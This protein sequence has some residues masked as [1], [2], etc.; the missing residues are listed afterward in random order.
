LV[1][2]PVLLGASVVRERNRDR[3][4]RLAAVVGRC[5]RNVALGVGYEQSRGARLAV[6]TE[7]SS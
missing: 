6:G 5:E 1:D 4:E 2:R 7:R 3:L